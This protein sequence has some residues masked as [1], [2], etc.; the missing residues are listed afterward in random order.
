ML[1]AGRDHLECVVRVESRYVIRTVDFA[2]R[3]MRRYNFW[4]QGSAIFC[5]A[6]MSAGT[7]AA[8]LYSPGSDLAVIADAFPRGAHASAPTTFLNLP[9]ASASEGLGRWG[10]HGRVLYLAHVGAVIIAAAFL[11]LPSEGTRVREGAATFGLST[12]AAMQPLDQSG[13]EPLAQQG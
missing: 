7:F 12:M 5:A 9:S 8:A 11:A 13:F 2:P 4:A 1:L 3:R 6:L 10:E